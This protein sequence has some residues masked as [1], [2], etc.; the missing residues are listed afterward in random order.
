[1]KT[2]GF[3]VFDE[4]GNKYRWHFYRDRDRKPSDWWLRDH[5]GY[6]RWAGKTWDEAIVTIQLVVKNHGFTS[7][8]S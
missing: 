3:N 6:E 8:V 5:D 7:N 2:T 4:Q 1:M